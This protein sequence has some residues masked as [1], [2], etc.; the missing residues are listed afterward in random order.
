MKLFLQQLY[1]SDK[2]SW[3]YIALLILSFGLVMVTVFDGLKVAHSPYFIIL[4][5]ILNVLIGMDFICRIKLVGCR[6]YIKDPASGKTRWWNIFD[7]IVV[8]FCNV[9]FALSLCSK[10]EVTKGFEEASEEA[11]II[12]WCVWQ[13]M[14]MVLIAKKQRRAR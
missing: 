10:T 11:L 12:M 8:T 13:T 6:K 4:E 9:V 5:L 14:R 1:Y 2:C 3:F 7:A